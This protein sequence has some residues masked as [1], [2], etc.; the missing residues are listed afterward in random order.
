MDA[1]DYKLVIDP[2]DIGPACEE[3]SRHAELGFDTETTALSPFDGRLRLVQFA[4][5]EGVYIFDLDRLAPGGDAAHTAALE[6][7]RR[8]LRATRPVK[9]AHNSKFDA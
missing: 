6:P 9:C 7:L 3:L 5:P 2:A 8:L 4:S 1:T